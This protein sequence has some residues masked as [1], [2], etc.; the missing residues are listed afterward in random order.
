MTDL[1]RVVIIA[2]QRTLEMALPSMVPLADLL[3]VL[4]QRATMSATPDQPGRGRALTGDGDWV[5]QRL[6]GGPLDDDLTPVSLQIRDGDSLYLRPR[7]LQLPPVHFDDLVDGL[8]TGVRNRPDRWRDALTRAL[9]LT[10]AA[11]ALATCLVLV[12]VAGGQWRGSASAGVAVVAG[13]GAMMCSRALGDG[14][15]AL[16]LGLAAPPFAAVAGYALFPDLSGGPAQVAALLGAAVAATVAALFVMLV[17]GHHR[18]LFLALLLVSAATALAALLLLLGLPSRQA[19]AIMV[20]LALLSSV[21]AAPLAFRLALLRLPQ[22]PTGAA[23]LA[24][25]IEPFSGPRLI[26][27]AAVADVYLTWLLVGAGLVCTGGVVVLAR[28]PGWPATWLVLCVICV[29]ALRTRGLTSGWQR[30]ATLLP[31]VAGAAVLAVRLAGTDRGVPLM[32]IVLVC[33]AVIL[34]GL[35]RSLPGRRVLPYWG[36]VADI[37]EY[38]VAVVMVLLLLKVFEIYQWARALSG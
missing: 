22:L 5:L 33:V 15:A 2:P 19:A 13:I 11:V 12:I 18:A 37:A 25:D 30:V 27:G 38:L 36:R 14:W 28:T 10:L 23:D 26:S 35:S 20:I 6:G 31:A 9:L 16:T 34:I 24:E 32:V 1:T 3:P 29:L 21:L 8:A 17:I 4:V 7:D